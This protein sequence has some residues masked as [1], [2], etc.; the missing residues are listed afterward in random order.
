MKIILNRPNSFEAAI[1]LRTLYYST[2]FEDVEVYIAGKVRRDQIARYSRVPIYELKEKIRWTLPV[3]DENTYILDPDANKSIFEVET[4]ENL[5]IDFSG[6]FFGRF[7]PVRGIGL[8]F[9]PYEA[10][11][12]I[13]YLFVRSLRKKIPNLRNTLDKISLYLAKRFL[14][15]LDS[16]FPN[17]RKLL[18]ILQQVH[19]IKKMVLGLKGFRVEG[20]HKTFKV[21]YFFEF[22]DRNLRKISEAKAFYSENVLRVPVFTGNSIEYREFFLDRDR[23]R[24]YITKD[25]YISR[26][27]EDSLGLFAQMF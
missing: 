11:S 5:L 19:K 4:P 15:F 23:Q 13:Y 17:P 25:F 20:N 21:T 2:Y 27:K 6:E 24:V 7:S 18:Y 22:F 10:V 12:A 8:R 14:D 3:L 1:V 26:E 16:D 9:Y